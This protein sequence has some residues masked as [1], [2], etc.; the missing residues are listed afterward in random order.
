MP[1]PR[2]YTYDKA[3]EAQPRQIKRRDGRNAARTK[4]EDL[5]RVHKG[6]GKDVDHKDHNT[7]NNS[8]SNIHVMSASANRAKH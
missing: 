2:D 6:D 7:T 8:L 4:L 3:Y 5:G 1:A